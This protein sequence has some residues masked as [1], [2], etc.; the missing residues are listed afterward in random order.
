MGLL[1]A[2]LKSK[3]KFLSGQFENE[4]E[5]YNVTCG[6]INLN[7]Q[8]M[9]WENLTGKP[10]DHEGLINFYKSQHCRAMPYN[11]LSSHLAAKAMIDKQPIRSGDKMDINHVST[12]MPYSDIFI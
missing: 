7:M 5:Q 2:L 9:K 6:V 3:Q 4:D 12:L 10:N 8:L 1:Q 11:N